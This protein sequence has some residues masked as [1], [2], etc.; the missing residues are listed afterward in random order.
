MEGEVKNMTVIG[1]QRADFTIKD[2]GERITGCNVYVSRPIDPSQGKGQAVDRIYVSDHKAEGLGIKLD[3]L[4]G[5]T[6]E[7]YYNRYGKV[8]SIVT[9]G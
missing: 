6:V 8:Q 5:K 1:V 3:S 7:V 2:S 9:E 4:I